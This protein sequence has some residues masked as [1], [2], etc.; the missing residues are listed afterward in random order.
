LKISKNS[1][2]NNISSVEGLIV[3]SNGDSIDVRKIKQNIGKLSA[4]LNK[5]KFEE[6]K[7]QS[8]QK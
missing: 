8:S 6:L 4:E 3:Q 7:L 5:L 2:N 1:S